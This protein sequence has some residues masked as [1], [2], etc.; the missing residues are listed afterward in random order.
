MLLKYNVSNFKSIADNIDFRMVPNSQEMD[1]LYYN[2]VKDGNSE[3]KVLKRAICYGANASGKSSFVES[4]KF[5]QNFILDGVKSRRKI[6]INQFKGFENVNSLSVFQF[7][8]VL[9]SEIFEYGFSLDA[10]KVHEEWLIL[11]KEKNEVSIFERV[12]SESNETTISVDSPEHFNDEELNIIEVF[13]KSMKGA[14]RNQLFLSK[15]SENGIILAENIINWFRKISIVSP[16]SS[17]EGLEFKI[18]KDKD[19]ASSLSK[20]LSE[21]DTGIKDVKIKGRKFRLRK[22]L[23]DIDVQEEI[24]N[25]IYDKKAGIVEINGRMFIFNEGASEP[26]LLELQ[27]VHELK[28]KDIALNKD[29]ESDG[30]KRLLDLLPILFQMSKDDNIFIIDELDRSFHTLITKEFLRRFINNSK[31][32]H[33]QLIATLHD[34]NTINLK[35]MSNQEIWF[36]NKSNDG[37]TS[38]KPLSDYTFEDGYKDEAEFAYLAG[39][40][41]GIPN[42]KGGY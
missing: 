25:E 19:F 18:D 26:Q 20:L 38:I 15:L 12:T 21:F 31:N 39:R 37:R 34:V 17:L 28:D 27:L 23:E 11:I 40:F 30:T 33:N 24:I 42:I 2:T 8:F 6:R 41:G 29:D 36:F 35:E 3:I 32:T 4:I 1:E 22:L 10:D 16:D 5:A 9:N 14:Q 13:K 7:T